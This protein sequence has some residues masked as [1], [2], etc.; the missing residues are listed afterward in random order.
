MHISDAKREV[1]NKMNDTDKWHEEI[2]HLKESIRP[3][4][5][6]IYFG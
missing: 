4:N 1:E 5:Y 2:R 6:V 3:R